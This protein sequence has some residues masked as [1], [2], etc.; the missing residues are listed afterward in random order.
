MQTKN[1]ER[2]I[3]RVVAALIWQNGRFLACQRPPHKARGLLWEFVGGKVEPGETKQQALIREC[4]EELAITV[5][6]ASPVM[7]VKHEY[8]DITIELTLFEARILKGEPQLLEHCDLRWLTANEIDEYPF[9]PADVEILDWLKAKSQAPVS[10]A[11]KEI[12]ARLK[13]MRDEAYQKFHS[14]LI[15]NVAPEQVL[16]VRMPLIRSCAKELFKTP[17]AEEFLKI[18]PHRYYEEN[19]LHGLLISQIRDLELLFEELDRFLPY[20]DNWATCDA[21]R[22]IAFKKRPERLMEK[23]QEWIV[24]DSTYTV[25]FALEMLMTYYLDEGFEPE[26]LELAAQVPCGDYYVDMM[27]AWYFATALAKQWDSAFPLI[28]QNRLSDWVHNKTIQKAIESL[29]ITPEQK[30]ILRSLK[31][32]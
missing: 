29:R 1:Q 7:S 17:T 27:A 2:N 5:A 10:A 25:R 24:S 30:E 13:D 12:E 3:V 23:I 22:P 21:I 15:P 8:P 6:V 26:H 11:E 19:N 32:N 14:A 18:L 4:Q 9:C 20:V 28:K 16:G 31:R